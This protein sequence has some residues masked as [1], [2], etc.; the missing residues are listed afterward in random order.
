MATK[1]TNKPTAKKAAGELSDTIN[2]DLSQYTTPVSILLSG[3]MISASIIFSGGAGTGNTA[4][5][6]SCDPAQP[7]SKG[8]LQTYADDLKL[9]MSDFNDCIE[10]DE[11]SDI[12]DAELE[13]ANNHGITGTPSVLIGKGNGD[14]I[15]GFMAGNVLDYNSLKEVVDYAIDNSLEDTLS[16]VK[17]QRLS[18]LEDMRIQIQDYYASEQ[19]GSLGGE[20]L[21]NKVEEVVAEQKTSIENNYVL[22][23]LDLGNGVEFGKGDVVVME[24]SDYEC[25]YSKQFAQSTVSQLKDEYIKTNKIRFVFRDFPLESIHANAR[26]AAEAARCAEEQDKYFEYHDK[27]FGIAEE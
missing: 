1:N 3:I 18:E 14:K 20:E 5:D 10:N 6:Y 2:I 23:E 12:I 4:I 26:N 21:N 8:C 25:P 19:G 27:L 17:K 24:F 7:L 22:K 15:Q 13:A 9:K 16:Y 11:T